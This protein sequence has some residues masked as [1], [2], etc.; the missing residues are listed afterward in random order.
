MKQNYKVY[1]N[2]NSL[3]IRNINKAEQQLIPGEIHILSE[4]TSRSEILSHLMSMC[5]KPCKFCIDSVNPEKKFSEIFNNFKKITAAGG[6]VFSS[7]NKILMIFRNGKW[8]LPKGKN[9]KN[10]KPEAAALRE[11]EEEC[12]LKNIMLKDK[13]AITY[14][15]YE[16]DKNKVLKQTHWYLMKYNG[17][18]KPVPQTEEGIS[19]VCW[20]SPPEIKKI[21]P[22]AFSL[23]QDL[24]MDAVL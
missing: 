3:W 2:N 10:E 23:I 17:D 15:I 16:T 7:Q 14:H 8:D 9:E 4:N 5:E 13:A 6:I 24:L 18:E 19:K 21:L 22:G 20:M 11:V 1:H 12:G